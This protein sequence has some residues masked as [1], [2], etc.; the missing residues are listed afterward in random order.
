MGWPIESLGI[1]AQVNPRLIAVDRPS[2][3]EKVTFIPM[4][5]VSEKTQSI[6]Q[7]DERPF[8][9]VSKGYTPFKRNDILIAKIT[10]CFEEWKNGIC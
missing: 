7:S 8:S 5:A 6:V 1:V 4:A 10:P 2:L 9:E 3:D